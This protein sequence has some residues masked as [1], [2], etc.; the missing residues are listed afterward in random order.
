MGEV[1]S[2]ILT[3]A[4]MAEQK[5]FMPDGVVVSSE[6]EHGS[7]LG[8]CAKVIIYRRLYSLQLPI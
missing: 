3:S 4:A 6:G 7:S 5:V 8:Q 1:I 2:T